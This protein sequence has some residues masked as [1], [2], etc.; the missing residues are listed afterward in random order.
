VTLVIPC[1]KLFKISPNNGA[2]NGNPTP[3]PKREDINT[4]CFQLFSL[5]G[6]P[7]LCQL[8]IYRVPVPINDREIKVENKMAGENPPVFINTRL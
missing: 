7:V 8:H 2:A 5:A 3:V 6:D 1:A 4:H